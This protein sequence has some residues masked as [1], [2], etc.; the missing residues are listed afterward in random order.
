MVV[1]VAGRRPSGGGLPRRVRC[2]LLP[3]AGGHAD[4]PGPDRPPARQARGAIPRLRQCPRDRADLGH[5]GPRPRRRQLLRTPDVAHALGGSSTER[6][7]FR[8]RRRRRG[9][10]GPTPSGRSAIPNARNPNP[11]NP[12]SSS[13]SSPS[14]TPIPSS[15][16]ITLKVAPGETVALI[17]ASGRRR[18]NPCS[19][20]IVSAPIQ[21]P[22]R[23]N[24]AQ[25][26]GSPRVRRSISA[27]SASYFQEPLLFGHL[28]VPWETSPTGRRP[29]WRLPADS[30]V[31]APWSSWIG[32][33]CAN[34]QRVP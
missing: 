21:A 4:G 15:Q 5:P 24:P 11:C 20:T 3:G 2:S 29:A 8:V 14:A 31:T 28:D 25:W 34:R 23:P 30:P 13:S 32:S 9:G 16:E 7:D 10:P 27:G 17:G 6:P 1:M 33:A 19:G 26:P 12:V 22:L 18:S